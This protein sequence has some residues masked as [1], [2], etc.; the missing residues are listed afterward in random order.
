[1]S[2]VQIEPM[3]VFASLPELA[4]P[5]PAECATSFDDH[6]Q[7]AKRQDESRWQSD[8]RPQCDECPS[9]DPEPVSEASPPTNES[10]AESDPEQAA[11]DG[12]SADTPATDTP[13]AEETVAS[14]DA[15]TDADEVQIVAGEPLTALAA[16]VAAQVKQ[17]TG[18]I[19]L[20][21][22]GATLESIQ[23]HSLPVALPVV[24]TPQAQAEGASRTGVPSTL[25]DEALQP[26]AEE[27]SSSAPAE[28]A[29]PDELISQIDTLQVEHGAPSE[30]E[31]RAEPQ[32]QAQPTDPNRSG[33]RDSKSPGDAEPKQAEPLPTVESVPQLAAIAPTSEP[34]QAEAASQIASDVFNSQPDS[35]PREAP[36][37]LSTAKV[38]SANAPALASSDAGPPRAPGFN[39]LSRGSVQ[40]STSPQ[41]S[42]VDRARF[43]QRVARAFEAAGEGGQLRLRLSPP[44]LGSLRLDVSVRQGILTAH[45]EAETPQARL[46]LLDNLPALR[47]RLLEQNIKIERFAVDL[48]NQSPGGQPQGFRQRD[49][50]AFDEPF[51]NARP[52]AP[53]AESTERRAATARHLSGGDQLNVVI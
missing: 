42:E 50:E 40:P 34:H 18:E 36:T 11:N 26:A 12:S 43:V 14:E 45:V 10:A 1:M 28:P 2:R 41:L 49:Q 47:E 17:A 5:P 8:P 22:S 16:V 33:K 32:A 20:E 24:S 21:P 38:E 19:S 3:N 25:L 52:Q 4:S 27:A 39:L 13:S 30:A 51:F 48:M 37:E 15:N 29:A 53:Q 9:E 31:P 23:D 44:E 46:L 7:Q 6:L 35:A